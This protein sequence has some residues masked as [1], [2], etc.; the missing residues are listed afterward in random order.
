MLKKLV[1]M[2]VV[3]FDR[4]GVVGEL[5]FLGVVGGEVVWWWWWWWMEPKT[6][7]KPRKNGIWISFDSDFLIWHW[8][9][10][11]QNTIASNIIFKHFVY[12]IAIIPMIHVRACN[13]SWCANNAVQC[14]HIRRT[15]HIL[16][17]TSEILHT[18]AHTYTMMKLHFT[19]V[20]LRPCCGFNAALH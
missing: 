12:L 6:K 19:T 20:L 13:T 2:I 16:N 15:F 10:N 11:I 9:N 14:V 5:L 8:A 17:P 1:R 18:Y 7:N 4:V 3:D